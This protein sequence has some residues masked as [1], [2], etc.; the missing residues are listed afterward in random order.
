MVAV[1]RMS[2]AFIRLTDL[3]AIC[4]SFANQLYAALSPTKTVM[5]RL[6]FYAAVF[7]AAEHL[8]PSV[9]VINVEL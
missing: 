8:F 4:R 5:S 3:M 1:A 7:Y 2:A 9:W 6:F